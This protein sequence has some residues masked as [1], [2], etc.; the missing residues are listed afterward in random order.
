MENKELLV[1]LDIGTTKI[2]VIKCK[3]R[4]LNRGAKIAKPFLTELD[5]GVVT[6]I[7]KTVHAIEKGCGR[8]PE[9]ANG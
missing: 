6:N 7:D 3:K 4:V 9:M 5:R 1:G 2:Q 8:R